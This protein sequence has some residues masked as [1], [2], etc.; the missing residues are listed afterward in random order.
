MG[1]GWRWAPLSRTGA[2][3][4][5][6]EFGFKY[7]ETSVMKW[8][9]GVDAYVW[10]LMLVIYCYVASATP[11]LVPRV[12]SNCVCVYTTHVIV[13]TARSTFTGH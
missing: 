9:V 6:H 5:L 8:D 3:R 7:F 1:G 10:L 11:T 4:V 2:A 12:A 13:V